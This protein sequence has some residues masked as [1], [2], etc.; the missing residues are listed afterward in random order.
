[1]SFFT[2]PSKDRST[3]LPPDEQCANCAIRNPSGQALM[4]GNREISQKGRDELACAGRAGDGLSV[5]A[6][7]SRIDEPVQPDQRSAQINPICGV[8]GFQLGSLP[9]QRQRV[10]HPAV[11]LL[12][13]IGQSTERRGKH[14]VQVDALTQLI[15]RRYGRS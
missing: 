4:F 6:G 13:Q 5:V 2:S 14:W 9:T 11:L 7:L 8:F 3:S 15:F 12:V 1:M 10:L